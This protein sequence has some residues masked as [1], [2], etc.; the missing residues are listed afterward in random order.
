MLKRV[1]G[2]LFPL[3]GVAPEASVQLQEQGSTLLREV[4]SAAAVNA[5]SDEIAAVYDD[6]PR[7]NRLAAVRDPEEDEDFRYEMFNRSATAQ[8][9]IA[10][11]LILETIEPLLGEDCPIAVATSRR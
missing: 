6:Y 1:H 7:D 8:K 5:L 4:L 3:E 10:H 2:Y 9:T 11:P